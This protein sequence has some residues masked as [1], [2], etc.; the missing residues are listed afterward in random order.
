[1]RARWIVPIVIV[2]LGVSS[3]GVLYGR[4]IVS[5]LTHR[6]GAP[7][8]TWA[9]EPL[10]ERPLLRIAVAGDIG[11]GDD[12]EWDT[13]RAMDALEGADPYRVLLLL[14]DN[15]YPDGDPGRLG[16]TVFRPFADVLNA[17]ARLLAIVGNHDAAG[18]RSLEQI[19]RLGMPNLWWT[20]AIGDVRFVGLDSNS[21]DDPE[22]LAWLDRTLAGATEPW[23]IVAIHESPYSA[24]YQGSNLDVRRRFVPLFERYGVQLVLSGHDH[25]YQR[26][27][28][29]GVTYLVSGAGGRTRG[30]GE[31][32]FTVVSYS[33]LHF[34]ELD[35]FEHRIVVRA[36][37]QAGRVFDQASISVE[38]HPE[39]LSTGA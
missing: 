9:Y 24:G 25:D 38:R 3:V 34:V 32:D 15:V 31:D 16:D 30:T 14:G 10:A 22:Q 23:R 29:G 27:V 7:E 11:E 6:K 28:V 21:V 20:V 19:R 2:L 8:R 39:P 12:E 1:M 4:Q 13:A 36:I 5:L 33:I 37:T 17:G 26:S 35:V 18:G